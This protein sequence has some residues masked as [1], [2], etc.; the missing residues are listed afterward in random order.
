MAQLLSSRE[1]ECSHRNLHIR[2]QRKLTSAIFHGL[3]LEVTTLDGASTELGLCLRLLLS[4][5]NLWTSPKYKLASSTALHSPQ[6]IDSSSLH[7]MTGVQYLHDRNITGNGTTIAII[8]QG[9]DYLHL[10]F[11]EGFGPNY[12]V[13]YGYDF[14]GDD[15]NAD[16]PPKPDHDPYADCSFHGTH[17]AGIAAGKHEEL[18]YIG[19]APGAKLHVFRVTG[20]DQ[21]APIQADIIVE[22]IL[23]AYAQKPHVISLSLDMK[24]GPYPNDIVSEVL[25]RIVRENKTVCVVAVG[26]HGAQGPFSSTSPASAPGVIAVGSVNVD[27]P[28]MSRPEARYVVGDTAHLIQWLPAPPGQ[29][30]ESIR[31][32]DMTP[33]SLQDDNFCMPLDRESL[34][35]RG[36]VALIRRRGCTFEQKMANIVA[37]GAEFALIYN[38]ITT[39]PSEFFRYRNVFP[40]IKGAGSLDAATGQRLMAHLIAGDH[41]SMMMDSGLVLPPYVLP[42]PS[43]DPGMI[44]GRGSWG[45]SGQLEIIPSI[46]AP[47]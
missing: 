15:V 4:V 12:T 9:V 39:N 29:F 27:G 11:G 16:N 31:L 35:L 28:V 5:K 24:T 21:D 14:V 26:N 8:D 44:S 17:V 25:G 20:C 43:P 46:L 10:A 33:T 42:Q 19:V 41:V 6:L 18:G 37:Y 40:G 32:C 38:N 1:I 3:S 2:T 22:A 23:A 45:P 13:Q 30:P 36:C 7:R 47:G 34:N